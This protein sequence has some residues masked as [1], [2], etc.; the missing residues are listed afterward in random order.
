MEPLL[1]SVVASRGLQAE[2]VAT[3]G[4]V[5]L[6]STS[7]AARKQLLKLLSQFCP[8][9]I[10]DELAFSGQ[11]KDPLQPG[12]P[13]VVGRDASGN[14]L[15]L[16]AKFDAELTATQLSTAYLDQLPVGAPGV[17]LFLVPKHR[18]PAVW[19]Q[20]LSGPGGQPP[21]PLHFALAEEEPLT[22]H[23]EADSRR[24]ERAREAARNADVT[25]F[26]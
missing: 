3:D 7:K 8:G 21:Q 6:L 22:S 19:S 4:L 16:E 14:R 15:V 23:L 18:L 26:A 2:P 17:L 12:R 13:D 9:A 24:H 20:I 5:H 10:F 11:V 25:A 1:S